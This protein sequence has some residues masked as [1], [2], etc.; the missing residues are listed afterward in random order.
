M[1][2]DIE[3][4][5]KGF[6]NEDSKENILENKM[7]DEENENNMYYENYNSYEIEEN[8]EVNP[9]I[10]NN[11]TSKENREIERDYENSIFIV[12]PRCE[13]IISI[14]VENSNMKEGII[15][16]SI[17]L[18]EGVYLCPSIVK[19][20]ENKAITVCL[21][22]TDK[23]VKVNKLIV[24]LEPVSNELQEANEIIN[25]N[26]IKSEEICKGNRLDKLNE[27]L[28]IDHLN[29]EEKESLLELC[30]EYNHIFH[31]EGD[32]LTSTNTVMHEIPINN[33]IPI[34]TKSY[35]YPEAL[36]E[37]VN[38]QI[39]K[40]LKD[41]II[42]PSSSPWNSPVWVVPKKMDASGK[43]KW[44]LVIDYRK[45]NEISVGDV[46]PLPQINDILDQLGH[47]KYFTTL[48][49][50]SGFHQFK[51]NPKDQAKTAISVPLGHYEY[52]RMPFGLKNATN[53]K[54]V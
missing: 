33:N 50:A 22:T 7:F 12:E 23:E 4:E 27:T 48:D 42:Q 34:N 21:N 53:Y 18:S 31:L 46:Y 40:L 45:L 54:L 51:M 35:R 24:K 5:N 8:C 19:V 25:V 2:I 3:H 13:K 9:Q 49:L 52:T 20:Q 1:E 14:R 38:D 36:K 44:R 10:E 47:S 30:R 17:I 16:E 29:K 39:S 41:K 11:E 28:R 37:E 32:S 26:K 15:P 6:K 43:K